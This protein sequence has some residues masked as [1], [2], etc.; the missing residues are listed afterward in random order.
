MASV[1][2]QRRQARRQCLHPGDT[3]E[4]DTNIVDELFRVGAA[5]DPSTAAERTSTIEIAEFEVKT[6]IG[7]VEEV[8][9]LK[10]EGAENALPDTGSNLKISSNTLRMPLRR[11]QTQGPKHPQSRAY[12]AIERTRPPLTGSLVR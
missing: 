9:N 7:K 10:D 2:Y 3:L 11:F 8:A 1:T 4:K 6:I 12:D 5:Q